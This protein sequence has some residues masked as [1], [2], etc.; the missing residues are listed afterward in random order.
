LRE[1]YVAVVTVPRQRFAEVSARQLQF[2]LE[3]RSVAA[4]APL[5]SELAVVEPHVVAV[6]VGAEVVATAAK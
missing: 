2:V 4:I 6:V 3:Q 1:S 5:P